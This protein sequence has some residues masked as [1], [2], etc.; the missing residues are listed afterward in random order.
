MLLTSSKVADF[1]KFDRDIRFLIGCF[2]EVLAELGEEELDRSLPRADTKVEFPPTV[3]PV[4][5][6]QMY[7]I[8]FLLLNMVRNMPSTTIVG[9]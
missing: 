2:R 7:S 4:R 6:A 5:P 1:D 8:A 3:H 9:H